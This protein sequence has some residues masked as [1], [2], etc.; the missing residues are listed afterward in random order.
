MKT[1]NIS[2]RNLNMREHGEGTEPVSEG[3]KVKKL[4]Q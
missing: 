4:R 3:I 2:N 1:I